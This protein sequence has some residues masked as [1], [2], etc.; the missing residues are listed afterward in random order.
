MKDKKVKLALRMPAKYD[1]WLHL[2]MLVL[3]ADDHVGF[4]GGIR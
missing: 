3:I 4:A 2:S 1:F